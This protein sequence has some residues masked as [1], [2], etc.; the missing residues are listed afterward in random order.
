MLFVELISI[1]LSFIVNLSLG[2]KSTNEN[3]ARGVYEKSTNVKLKQI[4][5]TLRFQIHII[6]K[7]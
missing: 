1:T 3:I 2:N 6:V 4:Y 7:K 5:K